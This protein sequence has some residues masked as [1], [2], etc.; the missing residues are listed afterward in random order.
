MAPTEGR[1][2]RPKRWWGCHRG[3]PRTNFSGKYQ[4][5]EHKAAKLQ[6]GLEKLGG[7]KWYAPPPS[8]HQI[9]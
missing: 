6:N 9:W 7:T 1:V 5:L 2:A 3:T 4:L 8:A